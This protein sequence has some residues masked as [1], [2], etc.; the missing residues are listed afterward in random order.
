MAELRQSG[1]FWLFIVQLL[2]NKRLTNDY[3][4]IIT[5]THN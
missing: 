2:E 5:P 1:L 4:I 3:L